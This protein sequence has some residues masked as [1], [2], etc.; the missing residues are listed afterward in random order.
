MSAAECTLNSGT[1][2]SLAASTAWL[3][4][5]PM[6][7]RRASAVLG[8]M[9]S[10]DTLIGTPAAWYM[11]AWM[12]MTLGNRTR[13]LPSGWWAT[14]ASMRLPFSLSLSARRT[15]PVPTSMPHIRHSASVSMASSAP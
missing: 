11:S 1:P 14:R 6:T 10:S 4:L 8:R 15:S 7:E 12:S 5:T 9:M 2:R 13:E 3:W